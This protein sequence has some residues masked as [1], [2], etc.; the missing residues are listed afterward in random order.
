MGRAK[1]TGADLIVVRGGRRGEGGWGRHGTRRA[2]TVRAS[3][4]CCTT[5]GSRSGIGAGP[6][7]PAAGRASE[8]MRGGV[9]AHEQ[10]SD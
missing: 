3:T 5:L 4:T 7:M 8:V 6:M 10:T 2:R 9:R 1:S